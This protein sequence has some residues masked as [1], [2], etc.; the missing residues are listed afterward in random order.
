MDGAKSKVHQIAAAKTQIV[1][2]YRM[3]CL[4][5]VP[6]V[7]RIARRMLCCVAR[8]LSTQRSTHTAHTHRSLI[9]AHRS[10]S[11]VDAV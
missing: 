4:E 5:T 3:S 9:G 1:L 6:R 2:A 11:E 10:V 7:G 8:F